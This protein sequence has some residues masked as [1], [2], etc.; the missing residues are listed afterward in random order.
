MKITSR[1]QV[2]AV[3]MALVTSVFGPRSQ[4]QC[5][6]DI[7]PDGRVD[8]GDLGVL[9]G[10]WG[11]RT[12]ATFSVASDLNLD[13]F[14][15]ANDLGDLLGR[16]GPCPPSVSQILPA[17]GGTGGGTSVIIT[18]SFLQGVTS[19]RFGGIPAT[20]FVV[21][22]GSRISARTPPRA[23]GS[24]DIQVSGPHGTCTL[25]QGFTYVQLAGPAWATVVDLEPD[26]LVVMDPVLRQRIV[27]T[28]WAW[29]VREVATQVE[30]L[31]VPPGVFQMGCLLGSNEYGCFSHELPPRQVE[32][33]SAFYLGRYEV[34][35]AQWAARMGSNPSTHSSPSP[36]VPPAQVL[37]RPVEQVSWVT[38]QGYLAATGMRLPTEA[39]WEY[40]CRAG[41]QTPFYNGST[42]DLTV[43]AL[44]WCSVNAIGQT[45]PV[46][47]RAA[48]PLGFHDMLGNVWEWVSDWYGPYPSVP[49]IDPTGPS[50]GESRVIRGGSFE[51]GS[52]AARSSAR[53]TFYTP[54][55]A[56][57]HLGFRVARNP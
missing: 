32:L 6:A 40:A 43:S 53:S 18:G 5:A 10:Y 51:H 11:P 37:N 31:L 7:V 15:D 3:A 36:E 34:T 39:E 52:S 13:G 50:G 16:W 1:W 14:V 28:G 27:S 45:R 44:A 17:A 8:G 49:E 48:N 9:L 41:T 21:E 26:P 56:W 23:P 29:R 57:Y 4:A 12:D 33:T 2:V 25:P 42:D 47:G 35:Q 46:G 19:V 20:S 22:S 38:V 54:Q 30:L 24:V 55:S